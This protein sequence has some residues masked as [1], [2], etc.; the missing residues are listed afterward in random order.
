VGELFRSFGES[1][2]SFLARE[3]P[4]ESFVDRLPADETA[5]VAVWLVPVDRRVASA[6]ASVQRRLPSLPWL[7]PLPAHFLHVT[8][9]S[10][11]FAG[12]RDRIPELAR[13][14]RAA[15]RELEPFALALPR[16]NCFH[17]AVVAEVESEGVREAAARLGADPDRFLPHLSLAYTTAPGP[18]AALRAALLRMRETDLG[19]QQ[20]R[21]VLLCLVPASRTTILEPWTVAER[22]AL[23]G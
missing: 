13:R 5:T 17:D 18:P 8:L 6:V 23:R 4:L 19:R 3:E 16:L 12:A 10:H 22:V 7:R 11:G 1:W 21:E 15:L 20:A 9:A 14:G 2:S